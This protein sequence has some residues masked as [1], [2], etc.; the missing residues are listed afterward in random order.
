MDEPFR[1]TACDAAGLLER[2][3]L[4]AERLVRACLERIG[5]HEPTVH[6]WQHLEPDAALAR[7]RDLDRGAR[8]GLLHGL[9]IGVK[10]LIDTA[11]MPTTYGSPIYAGHRPAA[12]APCVALARRQ[13][14][15]PLGKTVSTEFAAF[16]PG[17]TANPHNPAHT[18]GGSSS[19]SAAAVAA[20]MVPLAF[21]TQTAGSIIRP[22]AYCGVVGY[23]PTYGL[24]DRH[25]I[26]ALSDVLDTNGIIA[27]TVADCALFAAALT[28][29]DLRVDRAAV[30]PPRVG[31]V[32][33]FEWDRA[34]PETRS[35]L[36]AAAA[37]LAK[38][39]VAV[40]DIALP[41]PFARL[42]A[43]QIEIMGFDA[44]RALAW[45]QFNHADKVSERLRGVLEAGW[46]CPPERYDAAIALAVR[47]RGML[48]D[49]FAEV[50]VLLAPSAP[51]EAPE[52]LAATGDPLFNRMWT[53]LHVPCITVPAGYGPKGLPV[54]VQVIGAAGADRATLAA[55]AAIERIVAP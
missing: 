40:R 30:A 34:Q 10:D 7:A 33:T 37:K 17:P 27:R 25:G 9:P 18:P 26:K 53:L 2:G 20:G 38:G 49:T 16:T 48:P 13:G 54:G 39:G 31:I 51:G 5:T 3:E 12:D 32:R 42:A 29:R 43:A 21:G 6:A 28:G 14:A 8:T 44:A 24:I 52:G 47:C 15:I 55:A 4:T 22:A 19:G 50:D 1:L 35:T 41:G 36:E 46:Q 23:K 11:D 45:E